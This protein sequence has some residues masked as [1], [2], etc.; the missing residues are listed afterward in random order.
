MEAFITN[1][2][3]QEQIRQI[4]QCPEMLE[5][6]GDYWTA[7]DREQLCKLYRAGAGISEIAIKLQRV[8]SA[9]IM[10]LTDL[11]EIRRSRRTRALK[12]GECLCENCRRGPEHP[13]CPRC[14]K[15][16]CANAGEL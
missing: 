9:I 16:R 2:K 15:G 3:L 1:P 7:E 14:E 12:K 13:D 6:T 8:E 11:G 5:R 10:Q 4:R